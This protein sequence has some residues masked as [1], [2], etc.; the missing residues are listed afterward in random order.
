MDI[1]KKVNHFL[2]LIL[3]QLLFVGA[4][5]YAS[6]EQPSKL[7]HVKVS[8]TNTPAISYMDF[9]YARFIQKGKAAIEVE[10]SE[11]I[12]DVKI[13]P[14]SRGINF[15]KDGDKK[16]KFDLSSAA[17]TVVTINKK[18]RLFLFGDEAVM[19]AKSNTIRITDYVEN[20]G[21]EIATA[22]IQKALDE[23]SKTGKQLIFPA[24]IY[25]SGSLFIHANTNIF[26]EEGALLKGSDEIT[27]YLLNKEIGAR[28]FI[29]IKDAQ[30]V[31]IN[32]LGIIDGSGKAIRD[33]VGDKGRIRLF[34]IHG[35][36]DVAINGITLRDPAAWNTHIFKS[37]NVRLSRLKLL[38]DITVANTDG[39]DPDASSRVTI[40]NCFS[41]CSDD[42]V[43]VK[44]TPRDESLI[45]RD[46]S[47]K[48]CVFLTLKSSLK[49]GTETRGASISNVL[50]ENN[51]VIQSDRGMAIYCSDG[52]QISD[53]RFVNNRFEESYADLK[54]MGIQFRLNKRTPESR[55][56]AISNILVKDCNFYAAFPRPSEVSGYDGEHR[57]EVVFENLQIN[58]KKC[59]NVSDA[60]IKTA[61]FSNIKF[62]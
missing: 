13:S 45:T 37:D 28:I 11:I 29:T 39:F 9:N 43:A 42:N 50:F 22:A 31:T 49:V 36:K 16:I 55:V 14:I 53:V 23:A 6:N 52:A 57:T 7:F 33:K 4:I 38:N 20:K 40:E 54:Q 1:F 32:G 41:Y 3:V 10:F 25:R 30:N 61:T 44:L 5:A 58:G 17:Y 48:N 34:T 26:F 46:I 47:V 15:V 62:K 59:L 60:N 18:H 27:D 24:G 8:G 12:E 2:S 19:P 51:D 56:G 21:N 35:S